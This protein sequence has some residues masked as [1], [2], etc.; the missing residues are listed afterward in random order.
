MNV[1][2]QGAIDAKMAEIDGTP[3]KGKL[4]ANAVLGVSLAAAKAGAEA[5]GV[6]LY[7]HFADLAGNDKLMMPVPCFN[8]I[9]GG[10]HAGNKLPFQEYFV[11][12]TGATSF[13]EGML[14]GT[15]VYHTLSKILKKKFGGDATLIG[16]EGGFAPPCDARSGIE[17]VMEAVKKAGY[18]G[19]CTV[20]LDVA[21]S[22]FKVKGSP[23]G[24]DALYDLGMWDESSKTIK[25]SELMNFYQ[26]LIDDFPIVT[27]QDAFDE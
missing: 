4:G 19:Q 1:A 24:P 11:I 6:P 15:E 17:L 2:E 9:N 25:G 14:M 8:V 13:K 26:G 12:P 16:D 10:S 22:E 20:G 18:E 27:I 23:N 7:R 21:A 5:K 3:N